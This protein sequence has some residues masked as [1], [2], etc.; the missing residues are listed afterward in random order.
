MQQQLNL[1][2]LPAQPPQ[3]LWGSFP[4]S[5][6]DSLLKRGGWPGGASQGFWRA[7]QAMRMSQMSMIDAPWGMKHSMSQDDISIMEMLGW[8]PDGL[9]TPRAMKDSL[10]NFD[11][12]Q[13]TQQQG[14]NT[15][16][17]GQSQ[18]NSLA[19]ALSHSQKLGGGT[20]P[21]AGTQRERQSQELKK[22]DT[23]PEEHTASMP[24]LSQKA[25]TPPA[26]APAQGSSSS[27]S[28]SSSS[29]AWF[30][31]PAPVLPD[32]TLPIDK[33]MQYS[34]SAGKLGIPFLAGNQHHN[35]SSKQKPSK[36][37]L[38]RIE[39][40]KPL[41][42][43]NND[44]EWSKGSAQFNAGDQSKSRSAQQP[45]IAHSSVKP[46]SPTQPYWEYLQEV[47]QKNIQTVERRIEIKKE[48]IEYTKVQN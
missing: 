7:S 36:W 11:P 16:V 22:L 3:G 19:H 39:E 1:N 4:P 34:A 40:D 38:E 20:Q 26:P 48:E 45:S 2:Q 9:G 25:P 21:V 10:I 14:G 12:T 43:S 23:V 28:S 6:R 18:R 42:D 15:P 41:Q 17:W 46:P 5:Q 24:N 35:S 8:L 33:T 32:A 29:W 30:V 31:P 27:S 44:G 37:S 47:H 13:Q